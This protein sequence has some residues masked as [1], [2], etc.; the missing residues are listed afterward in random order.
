VVQPPA[1][2]DVRA[3][4]ADIEREVRERRRSGDIDPDL[5][6]ELDTA[7]AEVAPPG[8][9]GGGFDTVVDQAA[10]HA[11][12]DYDVPVT[13]R[14]P[15]RLVKRAVKLLT[16]WYMIFVGRQLVAFAGT[17]LR[18]LR[19]IGGRVDALE[20]RSPATD[21]RVAAALPPVVSDVDAA[22]W[23]AAVLE[24]LGPRPAELRSLHADCGDGALLVALHDAGIDV[25]GADPRPDAAALADARGIEVRRDAALD[26]LRSLPPGSLAAVVLSSCIDRLTLGDQ[27]EVL[28][29]AVAALASGGVLVLMGRHPDAWAAD[30]SPVARDLAP[31]RPLHPSTWVHLLGGHPVRDATLREGAPAMPEAVA[32][33][34]DPALRSLAAVVFVPASYLV[35]A[36]RR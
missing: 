2:I 14:R 26:H 21:P 18:A 20:A 36:Q 6:R 1:A 3:L 13:G 32:A 16:A 11:V 35:T 31:G 17:T 25:Y 23:A 12:V 33:S 7:F 24:A 8:A 22:Q 34:T 19:I 5:E 15:L 10:R 27:I 28:E 9:F 30:V 29:R 4:M